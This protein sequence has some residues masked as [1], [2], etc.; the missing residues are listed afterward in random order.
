[1]SESSSKL[2]GH[3]LRELREAREYSQEDLA[4]ESDLDRTYISML[5]RGIKNPTLQKRRPKNPK[6]RRSLK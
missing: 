5:E 4:N 6:G 3:A 2:F 1:M